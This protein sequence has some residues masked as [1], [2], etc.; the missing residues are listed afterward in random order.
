MA[1]ISSQSDGVRLSPGRVRVGIVAGIQPHLR[2]VGSMDHSH[3]D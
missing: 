3:Q 2:N 1:A